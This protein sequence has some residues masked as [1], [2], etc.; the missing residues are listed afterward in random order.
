MQFLT[1][2]HDAILLG[3]SLVLAG[4]ILWRV[5]TAIHPDLVKA[6]ALLVANHDD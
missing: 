6:E 3:A 1:A 2:H 4:V 5:S